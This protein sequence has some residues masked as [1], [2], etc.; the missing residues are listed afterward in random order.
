MVAIKWPPFQY[1]RHVYSEKQA[2]N[3][4]NTVFNA[5]NVSNCVIPTQFNWLTEFQLNDIVFFYR[6]L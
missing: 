3:H 2:L 6:I 5:V 4:R 1:G